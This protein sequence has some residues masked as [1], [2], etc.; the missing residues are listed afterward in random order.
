MATHRGNWVDR[1][2]P[3][4]PHLI[5]V[6]TRFLDLDPATDR[7]QLVQCA[8][9]IDAFV[10]ADGS[11]VD[12]ADFLAH[13]QR[14]LGQPVAP[15]RL[16][17]YVAIALWHIAKVGLLRDNAGAVSRGAS[18]PDAPPLSEWLA[19]RLLRGPAGEDR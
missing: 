6:L 7:A 8:Q 1:G 3:A 9:T 17:R 18:E 10:A 2:E 15:G 14:E 12:L 16:R 5:R 11:E 13:L 4:E 19:E